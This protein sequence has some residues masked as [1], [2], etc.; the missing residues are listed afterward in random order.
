[1]RFKVCSTKIEVSYTLI[2]FAAIG[3]IITSFEGFLFCLLSLI[4]HEAG[5]LTTMCILGFPPQKIK[6]TLFEISISDND[7]Y[8]RRF[9]DNF[10]IILC[11]PLFNFICFIVLYLLYL[12]HYD[13][14]FPFAAVNLSVGLFNLLPVMSLDGG[15]LLYLILSRRL[16]EKSA[17]KIVNIITFIFIFPLAALGFLLLFKS[18]YNFSLLFVCVYLIFSLVFKK[19]RYF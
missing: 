4:I 12:L 7:R 11:G 17:E 10:L 6:L 5:H 19:N 18:K 3:I 16:S 9:F 15:Q 2:C 13:I 14:L 8:C 1:M